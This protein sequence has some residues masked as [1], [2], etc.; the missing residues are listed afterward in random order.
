M[1]S[2]L[3]AASCERWVGSRRLSYVACLF[4]LSFAGGWAQPLR[5]GLVQQF[6]N[7][8][9]VTLR[10]AA[11][12]CVTDSAGD[13]IA[14][15]AAG[16]EV[17]LSA[18]DGAMELAR[19]SGA[20]VPAGSQIEAAGLAPDTLIIVS[21][22]NRPPGQY[23]GRIVARAGE[24]GILLINVV[25]V[26]D[27]LL[28]VLPAEIPVEFNPEALKAQA[29]AARTYAWANRGRHDKLGYDLCDSTDCQVYLGASGEKPTTSAAVKETAGLVA[30]YQGRPISA[31]YSADCGGM[32]QNGGAPYLVSVADR[33]EDG[34]PDY[35]EHNGH[36]WTKSWP[37]EEFEKLLQGSYPDLKGLKTISVTSTDASGRAVEVKIEAE[38]GAVTLSGVRLRSLSGNTVIRSAAFTVK[39]QDGNVLFEGKGYGHGIGLCQHGANAL[40]APPHNYTFDRILKHYY[41]GIEIV[42]VSSVGTPG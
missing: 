24:R 40:A 11:E 14:A 26:E 41:Q 23:R 19:A 37:L 25:D 12:F 28:G 6:S 15:V 29:V 38:K 33:P 17:T 32:T 7:L 2:E 13:T 9:Q 22:P 3:R 18:K 35:C 8:P 39:V 27:Y 4:L 34:G 42:P 16:G 31:Q 5:V 30:V 36:T 1:S 21:C 10:S 20:S